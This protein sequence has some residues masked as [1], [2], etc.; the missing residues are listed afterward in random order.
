LAAP[1]QPVD[2]SPER[3]GG[4]G[5]VER[6]LPGRVARAK[7]AEPFPRNR[8]APDDGSTWSPIPGAPPP[9]LS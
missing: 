8:G 1:V 9:A 5:D 6:E 2:G 4:L 3:P 7:L